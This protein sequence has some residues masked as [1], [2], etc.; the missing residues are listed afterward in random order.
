MDHGNAQAAGLQ[1]TGF[2]ESGCTGCFQEFL[3][4]KE[5]PVST[6]PEDSGTTV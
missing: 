6:D 4:S 2:L 5:I 1:E 3:S